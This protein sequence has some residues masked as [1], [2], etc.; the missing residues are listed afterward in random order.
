[1]SIS[2]FRWNKKRK[3]YSYSHKDKGSKRV[4]ILISSKDRM[5]EKKNK[6]GER[7]L[8]NIPLYRHPNPN[9]KGQFYVIPK[10]Y[11]DDVTSFDD[12]VYNW[13]WDKND[14]RSIKRIKKMKR[15]K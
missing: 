2:E 3:H 5:I 7:T 8:M 4:N 9:K 10:N 1:M 6:K 12:K 13:K 14:K 11:V 15:R